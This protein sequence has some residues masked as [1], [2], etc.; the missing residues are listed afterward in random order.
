[1]T[2]WILPFLCGLGASIISAW[3]VGGGTLL[4]LVMT[5]FLG[6][7]HRTAQ[8]INLL[9]FLPTAASA[10]FCHARNDCLDKPCLKN[11]VPFAVAAAL[12]GAWISNCVDVNV[13]R[14]PFG[15][16]LLLS[17]V[18]LLWPAKKEKSAS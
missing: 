13:L 18:S 5:L 15:V 4:L 10:L 3:G 8:G 9:F 12:I 7:D 2:A 6:V 14:K 16:Y 1:M 11:A 17:A